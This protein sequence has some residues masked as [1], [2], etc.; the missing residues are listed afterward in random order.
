MPAERFLHQHPKF[1][2]L[3]GIVAKKEAIDPYLAEKDYWIMHCLSGLQRAG[4]DFQ[5]KGRTSLLKGYGLIHHFSEDIDIRITIPRNLNLKTGK[6]HNKPAHSE[7]RRNYYENLA[8]QIVIEDIHPER[9]TSFDSTLWANKLVL[10]AFLAYGLYQK[11]G[12]H[13]KSSVVIN[14][15]LRK[16]S[17]AFFASSR[18]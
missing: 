18:I 14:P 3:I 11:D 1:E 15:T 13:F 9:D 16:F 7:D 10:V 12:S 17:C 8:R 4:Y 2:A 6:N 5:L